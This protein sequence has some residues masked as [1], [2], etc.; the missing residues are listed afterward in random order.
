MRLH[1][2]APFFKDAYASQLRINLNGNGFT[3]AAFVYFKPEGTWSYDEMHDLGKWMSMHAEASELWTRDA[4]NNQLSMNALPSLDNNT[5]SVPLDFKCGAE[6]TYTFTAENIS[7]FEAGTEIYLEDKAVEGP[8]YD[9]V[10]N[11]VYT[12]TAVPGTDE[13]FVLH[14]FGPTGIDDPVVNGNIRIY[15]YGQDAYIVNRGKEVIEEY[16]AYDLMG[17]ELHRGT[18]PSSTVNKV[19]IGNVSAYYIVKVITKSGNVYSEKVY[20]RK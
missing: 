6:D 13:R 15:G 8:W 4:D 16:V 5:V 7:S 14:F 10:A 17:R 1:S 2:T 9:L 19:T 11:P 3:D 12:F 18:L 20:I